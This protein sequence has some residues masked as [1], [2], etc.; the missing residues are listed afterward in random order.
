M[1]NHT[2]CEGVKCTIWELIHA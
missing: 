1:P 2:S